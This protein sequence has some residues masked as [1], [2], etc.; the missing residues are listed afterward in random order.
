MQYKIHIGVLLLFGYLTFVSTHGPSH[1]SDHGDLRSSLHDLF[2]DT[3]CRAENGLTCNGHGQCISGMCLCNQ[4]RY[5][6][7]C[8][9]TSNDADMADPGSVFGG[10]DFSQLTGLPGFV[11]S[12]SPG[13]DMTQRPREG[14]HGMAS[15]GSGQGDG[16]LGMDVFGSR[17]GEGLRGMDGFGDN[18]MPQTHTSGPLTTFGN[19]DNIHDGIVRDI[20]GNTIPHAHPEGA[21]A[22]FGNLDNIRESISR[23]NQDNALPQTHSGSSLA[24][25][26]NLDNPHENT[27]RDHTACGN[28]DEMPCNGRGNCV[29]GQ[30]VCNTGFSG[31]TCEVS[32]T[33]GFCLTYK[34]CAE[35][36]AFMQPCPNTCTNMAQFNLVYGFPTNAGSFRK[37]RFR[38]TKYSYACTFYF[39]QESENMFGRKTIMVRPCTQFR[40]ILNTTAA[41]QIPTLADISVQQETTDAP[42]PQET[43]T[44][45]QTITTPATD[46]LSTG[47]PPSP[48]NDIA[49]DN[50]ESGVQD[51]SQGG[52][53]S[54]A[55]TLTPSVTVILV[56]MLFLPFL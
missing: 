42:V 41:T 28:V 30:C 5:G 13:E 20:Q 24:T 56:G 27:V 37:C 18:I 8:A 40:D 4:G 31:F 3:L 10:F 26:G 12:E 44:T 7:K 51:K 49:T 39:Q 22:S 25:F 2:M 1:N 19:L 52:P 43:E 14:V 17:S 16:G 36:T 21:S 45:P 46:A 32:Q 38:S 35:C 9:S 33:E 50:G 6:A 23:D 53:G 34:P 15:F 54:L 47:T 11:S 55:A 29:D 48:S